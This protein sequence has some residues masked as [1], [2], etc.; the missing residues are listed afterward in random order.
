MGSGLTGVILPVIVGSYNW[1]TGW[2]VLGASGL[3]LVIIDAFLL[4]NDPGDKGLLPWG[5]SSGSTGISQTLTTSPISYS[6]LLTVRHFWLISTSYLFIALAAFIVT[7]YI[8]TYG[9]RELKVP[10]AEA[11][12]FITIISFAWVAGGVIVMAFSD[13][14]GRK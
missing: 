12:S 11:S 8:V 2:F 3:L 10:Y 6:K 5:E 7:D 1:R 14:V 4:R 13:F 9:V